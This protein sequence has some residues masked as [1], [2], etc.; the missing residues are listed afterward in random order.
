MTDN[1]RR[2][3]GIKWNVTSC[4]NCHVEMNTLWKWNLQHLLGRVDIEMYPNDIDT[5]LG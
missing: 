3:M 1:D 5:L 4:E 2:Q